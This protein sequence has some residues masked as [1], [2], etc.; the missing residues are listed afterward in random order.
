MNN[1]TPILLPHRRL[2]RELTSSVIMHGTDGGTDMTDFRGHS[3]CPKRGKQEIFAHILDL[4][5]QF[6]LILHILIVRNSHQDLVKVSVRLC[7]HHYV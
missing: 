4:T 2:K 1:G 6:D 5:H 3:V 7:I